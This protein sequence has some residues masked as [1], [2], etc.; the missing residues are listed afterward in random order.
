MRIS[1]LA[2][3]ISIAALCAPAAPGWA[4]G[5]KVTK[6]RKPPSVCVGLDESACGGKTRVL[7]APGHH[8]QNRQKAPRALPNQALC[9]QECGDLS[10]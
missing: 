2:A 6:I 4:E 8:D 10:G 3:L 9:K 1:S 5:A 7:L